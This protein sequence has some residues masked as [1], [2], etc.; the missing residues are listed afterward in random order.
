MQAPEKIMQVFIVLLVGELTL[1]WINP[2]HH[3]VPLFIGSSKILVS[4]L[5]T[6][7]FLSYGR[8]FTLR[9]RKN[10]WWSFFNEFAF[11]PDHRRI[12]LAKAIPWWI[13]KFMV[14]T[15]SKDSTSYA[16]VSVRY[17]SAC[18]LFSPYILIYLLSTAT[19]MKLKLSQS[20]PLSL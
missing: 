17:V 10:L 14:N 2:G 5:Y 3:R 8:L 7:G 1:W 13:H 16:I 12:L 15:M 9:W 4:S 11:L 20:I 6:G 19:A 18:R